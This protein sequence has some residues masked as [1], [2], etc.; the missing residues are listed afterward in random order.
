MKYLRFLIL[1]ALVVA[2]AYVLK[3]NAA[4]E[5]PSGKP[6]QGELRTNN[7]QTVQNGEDYWFQITGAPLNAQVKLWVETGE[8]GG[9]KDFGVIGRTAQSNTAYIQIGSLDVHKTL[10]CNAYE[11][12][13]P[14]RTLSVGNRD[15]FQRF[16]VEYVG[17]EKV[18]PVSWSLIDCSATP[19]PV[20]T[21]N[22]NFP[23]TLESIYGRNHIT[24]PFPDSYPSGIPASL[25]FAGRYFDGRERGGSNTSMG[26]EWF[27][28][29]AS[30]VVGNNPST[31][32]IPLSD[33]WPTT[34]EAPWRFLL[35]QKKIIV[36]QPWPVNLTTP[37]CRGMHIYTQNIETM[38]G[39][40]KLVT[41]I[42]V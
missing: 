36:C 2:T 9:F 21:N 29:F 32:K 31:T 13:E 26:F 18:S 15:L 24:K 37:S 42:P 3:V 7:P 39:C 20:A 35:D 34:Q 38:H 17:L 16:Y 23:Y 41:A 5:H 33:V 28:I 12:L 10:D 30:N 6:V 14:G 11:Y 1:A 22:I 4:E 19:D 27:T 8:G 40:E 25:K